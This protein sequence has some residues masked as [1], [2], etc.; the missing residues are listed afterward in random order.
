M[1]CTDYF[2][3]DLDS[4]G[5]ALSSEGTVHY[6]VFPI[7]R[8]ASASTLPVRISRSFKPDVVGRPG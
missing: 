8:V 6:S 1:P 4:E 2:A 7:G 5:S 3:V